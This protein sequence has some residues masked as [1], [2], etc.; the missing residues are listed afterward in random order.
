[1]AYD[2]ADR[3]V[4]VVTGNSSS[5]GPWTPGSRV[6]TWT[7]SAGTWTKLSLGA[8][9]PN[10]L[11]GA[12]AYDAKDGFVVLFGGETFTGGAGT[13]F[14]GDTW[15]Y[16]HGTWTN[17]TPNVTNAPSPREGSSMVWDAADQYDLM[18][19][20][21][22]V[23]GNVSGNL[24]QSWSFVGGAWTSHASAS[25][26]QNQAAL[27]YDSHD[28]YVLSF[29]GGYTAGG[30]SNE[31]WEYLAGAWKNL[32]SSVHGAPSPRADPMASDDPVLG[33][34]LLFGGYIGPGYTW[35]NDSWSYANGTWTLL[36]AASGPSPRYLGQMAFDAADNT[37]ILF[38]GTDLTTDFS[39]TWAFG[40][41]GNASTGWTQAA[42]VLRI[43]HDRIDLGMSV[44]FS[45]DAV[46]G[47]GAGL[48]N[49]TGLPTGCAS[50]D[51]ASLTCVPGLA[52]TFTVGMT[53][54]VSGAKSTAFTSL[55]VDPALQIL[56]LGVTPPATDPNHSVWIQAAAAGG[57]PALEF[58]YSGLPTGCPSENSTAWTCS[59][60]SAGKF[61]IVLTLSDAVGGEVNQTVNLQVATTLSASSFSLS[62]STIDLSQ[63][64][65]IA[66]GFAGGVGPF[67]YDYP[68]LPSGCA[69]QDTARL[70]CTPDSVGTFAVVSEAVD[71]FGT[72]ATTG[73]SLTVNPWPAIVSFTTTAPNS[74]VGD[75][76]TFRAVATGGTGSLGYSYAGL[77]TG[78]TGGNV[79]VLTCSPTTA[80]TYSVTVA[81]V[82]SVGGASSSP[83]MVLRVAAAPTQPVGPHSASPGP[84]PLFTSA[85]SLGVLVG[86]L[87]LAGGGA[88]LVWRARVR[89]EG[90]RLVRDL[91]ER[92]NRASD[93]SP[94]DGS[95]GRSEP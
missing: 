16:L 28:G 30:N 57:T 48:F 27:A 72:G 34:I 75:T 60:G 81:I 90:T 43:S 1:M 2:A 80:G 21:S 76:L 41:G 69:T 33:G 67:V 77:P 83:A 42:P 47:S 78:C 55:Q 95:D 56:S 14:L 52:G 85:F 17:L 37:T 29:G 86:L 11:H 65:A 70:S 8:S 92:G 64:T 71:S 24:S 79:A 18:F 15:S 91:R 73:G 26:P 46:F 19:G 4:L 31:T 23:S 44:T 20:G 7:F 68:T 3:Y 10:R 9:P 87:A 5:T 6:D 50:A 40:A 12:L 32:T 36:S 89:R 82:D 51:S 45:A 25:G 58:T 35:A 94:D 38:G 66:V 39:D 62:P 93:L 54:N 63:S 84:A 88:V 74:T 59:P 13:H 49:Y 53:A 61:A 22:G